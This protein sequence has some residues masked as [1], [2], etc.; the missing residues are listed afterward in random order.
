MSAA[1][2]MSSEADSAVKRVACSDMKRPSLVRS[3]VVCAAMTVV[4]L[5]RALE[6][7]FVCT[8]LD[9]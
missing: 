9:A 1:F 5:E 2:A 8:R 3:I 7:P 4:W 6:P